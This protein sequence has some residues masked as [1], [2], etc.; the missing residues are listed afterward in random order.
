[1]PVRWWFHVKSYAADGKP[2]YLKLFK[3]AKVKIRRHLKIKTAAASYDS[4]YAVY[5]SQREARF[6]FV[7]AGS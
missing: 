3:L 7:N 6:N 2:V 4:A 1:M 5:F